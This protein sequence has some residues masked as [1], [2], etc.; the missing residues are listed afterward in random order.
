MGTNVQKHNLTLEDFWGKEGCNELLV[1]SRPDV[2]R[3]V[4]AAFLEAGCDVIETDSFGSTSI[5]LAE[6]DLQD[7]TRELNLAAARLARA[8]ADEYSTPAQPRFVAGSIGPTTKL[9]SLGHIGYD[10]MAAAYREQAEALIEGGVDVLLIETCQDLLQAKIAMAA[11][12]DAMRDAREGRIPGTGRNVAL[13]IQITLEATGTMLLGSEIGAALAVLETF[14]PDVIGLNCATGPAEMNDAVRFLCQNATVP[15]SVLPNAG[16]PQNEGGHAVYKLTPAELAAFHRRFVAEY[17]VQVVGGCCGTTPEHL[18]A[19][20]EALKGVTPAPRSVKPQS[21]AASAF[22]VVPLEVDGQPVVI[23]EEMNTTTRLETFRNM[24]RGGDYDGILAMAK[25]LVAEGSQML[26]L[27]CAIV[28]EDEMAYMNAVLE[29]IATRVT[30]PILVDSTEANV[31]EEALKRIPG[32]PII[33]SI[34]L[35]D[36]EKRTSLVLPMARRYG[37]AVIALTIDEEGMALTADRK[38]AIAHRIHDLAVNKYGLRAED[39]IFDPLTLPISTGQEDYRSAAIETLEAVRR[40]RLELPRCKTVLGVSNIS[41]GLNAYA[42]R[43]LNSVFLKEAV[44][45][46]LD[47]AIVNYSKIYPLYKIPEAEVDLARKLIFQDRTGG[48]PLQTYMAHFTSLT[49]GA[50]QEEEV[51][52]ENLSIEEKLKQLIIR[53]ERSIG[54]GDAKQSLEEAL[55]SALATY[56]PLDLINTVLLDGMKTVGELFGARKM[57]LPSVLDSAAVMKAAVAYLEPKMEKSDSGGKGTMVLATVKGDVHDIGKNLVDIILSNNG[58]R[59]VNLGIKQPSD[60][61][62][63][64]AREAGADAIGL[65]GLLV[66]STL[67]MKYVL[68]DL[69]RLGM[70]VPV[71]CGG[72][73]L[74]RKYVEDDLRKEYAGPVFYAED[75]FAGL[76]VITDLTSDDEAARTS[77][78]EEGKTV[79]VFRKANVATPDLSLVELTP[80]GRS[81]VVERVSPIPSPAFWGVRVFKNYNLAEV[82]PY[83]NETALFKNQWQLKTAAQSDYLRLVEEKYRPILL[84]LEKEVEAAGWFE[85]KTIIAFYPCASQ[86]NDLVVFDP[87]DPERELERITFP[88]QAQGRRLS[89]A[90][91][92]EPISAAQRDVV[93]FSM[94]TIGDEA[95]RQ[96]QK[97]FDAGGFTKYLYLHGLSVET[98]EALA[99]MTHKQA[100]EFLSIAGEDAPRVTDLFHQK[101]RGSR[102]SFG[103]PACPNLE[104]QTKI[105]RLLKPEENIGVRLTEGFHLEPEQSTNAIVVHHPQAKYF[106]V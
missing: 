58:Y 20:V 94:V 13:Q 99:E 11:C 87:E 80:E 97:L 64:A 70:T 5:V 78:E 106:V 60:A 84:D 44:D 43:V 82:F 55:E 59:V 91:F 16:L 29:K 63:S 18:H 76:H 1:L 65:S 41:F 95:S 9:P 93:G 4:H 27:C 77:R 86:G 30:A 104:D 83:L 68:Q 8:V 102:Y 32:K 6:Y 37:A 2:I 66:K 85:P 46:G 50:V 89:I 10:A 53:G 36:G 56:T 101:Y 14:Q 23:A 52:V 103:Y 45:R 12:Q 24:V 49:K 48:D 33:N 72:A 54:L 57:Q 19:V 35:E 100:R 88:R 69:E 96:T 105:F 3:S 61:I 79:K 7:R 25:R 74:T 34:N 26:D 22:S 51:A 67:E 31:I 38:V 81:P 90:D 21:T 39:L 15:I 92:F 47:A 40:I 71:I 75:A 17:G 73:A 98:A 62:I 28:G 42:R